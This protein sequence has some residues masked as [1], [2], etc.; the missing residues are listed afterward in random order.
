MENIDIR[1]AVSESSLKYRDIAKVMGVGANYLSRIM[2][3]PLSQYHR[4]RILQAIE[5]LKRIKNEQR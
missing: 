3:K 5:E 1:L 4:E 2:R